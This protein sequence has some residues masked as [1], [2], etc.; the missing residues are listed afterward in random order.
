MQKVISIYDMFIMCDRCE[1]PYINDSVKGYIAIQRN[2][3]TG[4][5]VCYECAWLEFLKE[6]SE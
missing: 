2:L 1:K 4:E 5:M 3:V 6:C